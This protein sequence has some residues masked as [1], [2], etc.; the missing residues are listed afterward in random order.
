MRAVRP[1]VEDT[2]ILALGRERRGRP[3]C[4]S[5]TSDGRTTMAIT[6]GPGC[7]VVSLSEPGP[8]GTVWRLDQP[9]EL[10]WAPCRFGGGRLF[11]RCPGCGRKVL[12]LY[13]RARVLRCRRCHGLAYTSQRSQPEGALL[14]ARRIRMGLGGTASLA[15]PFPDRPGGMHRE[16]YYRLFAQALD[17]EVVWHRGARR[18]VARA[19]HL[20]ARLERDDR[21]RTR[22]AGRPHRGESP[23]PSLAAQR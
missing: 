2:A 22:A 4:W 13:W 20:L 6:S 9:A 8:E 17:A 5:W 16:T 11:V 19:E 14:R 23:A 1:L 7:V 21:A 12:R 15:E 10:V 3:L 18:V